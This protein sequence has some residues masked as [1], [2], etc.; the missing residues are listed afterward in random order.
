MTQQPQ[1]IPKK[2]LSGG[3]DSLASGRPVVTWKRAIAALGVAL[4]CV[5]IV[6][7]NFRGVVRGDGR[8][9]V[10][11]VAR[12]I[13]GFLFFAIVVFFLLWGLV[14]VIRGKPHVPPHLVNCEVCEGHHSSE[15]SAC[16][17]CGHP[18]PK[19]EAEKRRV[20]WIIWWW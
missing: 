1:K 18:T 5:L 17:T 20:W 13:L 4:L 19:G 8:Y 7:A 14:A 9:R 12:T 2:Y 16:P 6:L 11:E 3:G 10:G 15:A